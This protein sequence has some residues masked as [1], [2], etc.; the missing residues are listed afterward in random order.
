MS[1]GLLLSELG[2]GGVTLSVAT[3]GFLWWRR[4]DVCWFQCI[5]VQ[6]MCCFFIYPGFVVNII[7]FEL[8]KSSVK[9]SEPFA[10]I[11]LFYSKTTINIQF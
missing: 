1:G 9:S 5:E 4:G 10:S 3:R 2:A 11:I 6:Q 7:A 8:Q